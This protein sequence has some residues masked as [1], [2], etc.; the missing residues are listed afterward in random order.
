MSGV[1]QFVTSGPL[2]LALPVAAAAKAQADDEP[3]PGWAPA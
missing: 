2:I 1:G 3:L